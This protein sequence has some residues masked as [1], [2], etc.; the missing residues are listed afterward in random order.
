[1]DEK[2]TKKQLKKVFDSIARYMADGCLKILREEKE[3]TKDSVFRLDTFIDSQ[4]AN[5]RDLYRFV[6]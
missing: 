6:E 1:M 4:L 2:M 3:I 5:I